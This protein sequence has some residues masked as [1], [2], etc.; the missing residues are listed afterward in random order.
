[1]TP[2]RW[3]STYLRKATQ[4][5]PEATA[6]IAADGA[7][8]LSD[9]LASPDA[10]SAGNWSRLQA[11]GA[12]LDQWRGEDAARARVVDAVRAQVQAACGRF[13]AAGEDSAAARCRSFLE[14][15]AA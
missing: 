10:F 11:V 12:A 7:A 8:I 1:M 6:A 15:A 13:P 3:G 4:L 14:K 2:F 5:T 9:L